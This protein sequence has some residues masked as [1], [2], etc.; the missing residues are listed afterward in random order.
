M[1]GFRRVMAA[2]LLALLCAPGTWLRSPDLDLAPATIGLSRIQAEAPAVQG[3][4]RVAGVWHYDADSVLFGGFSALIPLEDGRLRAFSDRGGQFSFIQPDRPTAPFSVTSQPIASDRLNDRRDIEAATIDA[5]SGDTWLA[6]E[7]RHSVHRF[8]HAGRPTGVRII[9][10]GPL[11]WSRNSGAEAMTRLGDGRF[12]LLPERGRSGLMFAG[13][14]VLDHPFSIVTYRPPMPGYAA[15]DMAQLPDGRILL[16]LRSVNL[17]RG[18]PRFESKLAIAPPPDPSGSKAW[19]PQIALD[20]G[21]LIPQEN[22]EGMAV[23]ERDDGSVAVWLISD[24]NFSVVQ[25]TLLAQLIF[26]APER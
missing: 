10:D 18:L 9:D 1:S 19:A 26:D 13:D 8:D 4:W 16:L 24:D 25:R 14:P 17:S 11:D 7:Q 5:E 6:M 21:G 2:I 22:Y 20:L 23:R 12:L 15:T 3:P